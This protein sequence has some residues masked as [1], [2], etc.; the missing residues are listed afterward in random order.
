MFVAIIFLMLQRLTISNLAIIENVD[1]SFKEGFTVLTGPTGAGKSLV[2]DSLSLLLGDRASSELIRAG[3]EKASIR[4]EFIISSKRL[5]AILDKMEIP[6]SSSLV[7]ERTITKNKNTIK[8]NGATVTLSDLNKISPFLADIHSQFDYAKILNH[9]NYLS[10]VDGYAYERIKSYKNEYS[11]SLEEYNRSSKEL[12]LLEEQKRKLDENRDFYLFQSKELEDANLIEGEEESNEKE[13]SLLKNYDKV[14]SLAKEADEIIREDFIDRL[15]DLNKDL[16]KLSEYNASYEE[17]YKKLDDKYYE[18]VDIFDELKKKF[19][20]FD[21]DPERLNV[22]QQRE[23]D[24][25]SLK[26]KYRKSIN[27]LIAYREELKELLKIDSSIDEQ[28]SEK[29][30]EKDA[31]Y[32]NLIAKGEDLSKVRK[33][34]AK[35]I[36]EALKKN[37]SDLLLRAEFEI[38]F[39]KVEPNENGIDEV[40]FLI[41]TNIGEGKKNLEKTISGGEASRIMLAFKSIF[42][43]SN[44]IETAIFDEIDVGISGEAASAVGKKIKEISLF[45]QVIA[46]TH[47]PQVASKSDHHILIEKIIKDG[48]TYSIL[49]ELSLEEKIEQIA[50]LISGGKVTEKQLEY[51][52]E[53]VLEN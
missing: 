9:D 37:L 1:I 51:A 41:E 10:M 38:E 19:K 7:V 26:R 48:R 35:E 24:L 46:I 14:Y 4:G 47:L 13:L 25:N 3:E 30:K 50:K 21:Y 49:K 23:F 18:I 28:I 52:K 31:L 29:A 27:E 39:V 34:V 16:L 43:F 40:N 42:L 2:I 11:L 8:I 36:E 33:Q 44:K 17:A 45:R 15:Y 22:L 20:S 12:S 5:E 32:K 6:P 53:M